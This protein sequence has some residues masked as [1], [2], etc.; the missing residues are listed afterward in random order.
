MT[1]N[2]RT[3]RS[4]RLPKADQAWTAAAVSSSDAATETPKSRR[5]SAVCSPGCGGRPTGLVQVRENRGATPGWM[6]PSCTITLP[7]AATCGFATADVKLS[8]GVTQAS[9]PPN[10]SAQ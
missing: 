1:E 4:M 3:A 7:R 8:T 6:C 10:T 2:P 9:V 5:T